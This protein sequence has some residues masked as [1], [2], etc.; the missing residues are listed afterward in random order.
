MR[1]ATEYPPPA[2]SLWV[3]FCIG[4]AIGYL[5]TPLVPEPG[6]L[7]TSIPLLWAWKLVASIAGSQVANEH[8]WVST[9]LSALLHGAFLACVSAAT[10]RLTRLATRT[11]YLRSLVLLVLALAYTAA[12]SFWR[13]AEGP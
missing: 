8:R 4:A 10:Y 12:L 1:Q 6:T 7:L 9:L 5:A 11:R 13:L 3:P 2:F